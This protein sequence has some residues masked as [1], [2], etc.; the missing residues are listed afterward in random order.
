VELGKKWVAAAVAPVSR[1]AEALRRPRPR[2][3]MRELDLDVAL[4]SNYQPGTPQT[5]GTDGPFADGGEGSI[6]L[7]S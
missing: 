4:T 3:V 2:P 5:P 6:A 7:M 1:I